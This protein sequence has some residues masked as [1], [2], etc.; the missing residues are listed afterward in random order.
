MCSLTVAMRLPRL[1]LPFGFAAA[2]FA[3][4]LWITR[5]PGPGLDPDAMSYLGAA[6]SFARTG[7]FRIPEG[8]WDDADGTESLGH[9][10]PGFSLALAGP[11]ALGADPIQTARVV[12]AISAA[13]AVGLATWLAGLTAGTLAAVLAGALAFASPAFTLDH[14]RV[15]S[16]PLFLALLVVTLALMLRMRERPLIYGSAA[17]LAGLVRYAGVALGAAAAVWALAGPGGWRRRLA[18]AVLAFAPTAL[19]QGAWALRARAE[20]ADVRTFGLTG[21]FV[22]T[23]REGW[24]TLATWLAPGIEA[25]ALRTV[26]ALAVAAAACW[27]LWLAARKERGFFLALAIGTVSYAGLVVVSR[28]FA[29]A[30]IPFDERLLSPLMAFGSLAVAAAA[31]TVWRDAGRMARWIG[32]GIAIAWLAASAWQTAIT[33][34]EAREGGW[35]Y[36]GVE[37]RESELVRWLRSDG[38][39][40][41]LYTNSP[42]D[43][44]FATGRRSWLLPTSLDAVTM[45]AFGDRLRSTHGAVVSFV[46][47][48]EPEADPAGLASRLG[49]I[50]AGRF[51]GVTVWVPAPE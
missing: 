42:A 24:T 12:E 29:D 27:L 39:A 22:P 32:G 41:R 33:V 50:V 14:L 18:R 4:V 34:R 49:L 10:P 30:S 5:P 21:G 20:S 37:W 28:L 40:H 15:L 7:A 16:E 43:V 35:G 3:A 51:D 26:G 6:E 25:P 47:P 1:L 11:V 46:N 38:A 45:R 9:F 17:A 13:A 23:F 36:A 2:A 48:E 44:W 19:V 31:A 8:A